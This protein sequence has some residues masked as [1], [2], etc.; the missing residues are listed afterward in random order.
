MTPKA[1]KRLLLDLDLSVTDLARQAG[2]SRPAA[3]GTISGAR[4][5][6]QIRRK[7]LA[8]L[9][10]RRRGLTYASLWDGEPDPEVDYLPRGPRPSVTPVHN[11]E[12][13]P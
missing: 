8:V 12:G 11:C 13:Q 7:L 9:S 6:P 3:S 1:R 10:T 5:T 4:K 2:V